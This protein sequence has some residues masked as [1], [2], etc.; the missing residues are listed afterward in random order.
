MQTPARE[1]NLRLRHHQWIKMVT[2]FGAL[3]AGLVVLI[4]IKNLLLSVVIAIMITYIISPLVSYIEGT[5]ISRII[6]ILIVYC[7]V[8][9][10]LGLAIWAVT[11]LLIDQVTLLRGRLP[12]YV[13]GTVRLFDSIAVNIE[14]FSGGILQVNLSSHLRKWLTEQ[15]SSIVEV[16]PG[17]LSSSA[18]VLFLSPIIGFFILKDG[19]LFFR[20]MLR[21]VPNN[22]F[23]LTLSL[24]YQISEQIAQY[25]RARLLEALIVG[26]VCLIGFWIIPFPFAFLLAV[27]AALANLIPYVGPLFGAAPGIILALINH[28]SG[29]TILMVALVY[30]IAQLIDNF[31]IIPLVVARIVNLHPLT[32]ILVVILGAQTLGLLGMFISIPLASTIK[33]TFRNVYSHL[34]DGSA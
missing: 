19:H 7:A 23:E 27:F 1:R 29:F 6:A 18:S 16:L 17:L 8:S 14:L 3:L 5:G 9:T 20:E 28:S 26:I 34:T 32:V 4:V 11:P 2:F 33:V 10:I 22:I 25:F 13:E 21:L 12:D 30:L 15:S 24:Q 31:L